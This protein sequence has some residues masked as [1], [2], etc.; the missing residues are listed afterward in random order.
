MATTNDTTK[1][2]IKGLE[3]T[4]KAIWN[5]D[6]IA[7]L[8]LKADETGDGEFELGLLDTNMQN[9][10][11]MLGPTCETIDNAIEHL[12]G[13]KGRVGGSV[14]EPET[15]PAEAQKYQIPQLLRDGNR[16]EQRAAD[17]MAAIRHAKYLQKAESNLWSAEGLCDIL[18][19][20]L[21]D[22]DIDECARAEKLVRQIESLVEKAQRR[23]DRHSMRHNNLFVAYCESQRKGGE[24]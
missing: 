12:E 6:A 22:A 18:G 23:I 4:R 13:H 3:E 2:V 7:G 17:H 1:K 15:E 14:P 24:K 10:R 11:A 5:V 8:I 16:S 21:R 20:Y 19:V 9:I